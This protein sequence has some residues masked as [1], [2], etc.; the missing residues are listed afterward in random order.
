MAS[1]INFNIGVLELEDSEFALESLMSL[2]TLKEETYTIANERMTAMLG[3]ITDIAN[4][5]AN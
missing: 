2:D 1:K 3:I 5:T 4:E